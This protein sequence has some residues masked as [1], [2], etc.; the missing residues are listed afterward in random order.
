VRW[1][2]SGDEVEAYA[3]PPALRIICASPSFRPRWARTLMTGHVLWM[4]GS[5]V[6]RT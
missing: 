2:G 3:E 4:G 6:V 5:Q 1:L